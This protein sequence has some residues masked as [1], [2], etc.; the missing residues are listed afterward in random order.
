M[1]GFFKQIFTWWNGNTINTRFFTW[2]HGKRIG[3]DQFG[4]IYYEGSRHK[5]GYLRRWVIYKDYSEASSI[6]PGWHG[7]IHHRCDIPPTEENYQSYSW[8]KSHILNM[9]GTSEAYRPK[10]SIAYNH[11]YFYAREDYDAW[12]PEE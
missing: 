2:R 10:G 12:L 11:G 3:E 1:S 6:P 4:N 5:D 8:E 7:W 9:T